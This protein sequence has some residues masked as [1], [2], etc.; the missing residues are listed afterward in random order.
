M[1][2]IEIVF[3]PELPIAVLVAISCLIA[4]MCIWSLLN[5]QP[6]SVLRAVAGTLLCVAI[7]NPSILQEQREPLST[8]IPLVIDQ[9]SSQSQGAR[10]GQTS[11][12]VNEIR[13]QIKRMDG[14]ELREVVVK[15]RISTTS[16]IST[17][18]FAALNNELQDVPRDRIGGYLFVTD[19][20][21][22]D[23]PPIGPRWKD[24]PPLHAFI[25][26]SASERDRKIKFLKAPRFGVVGEI[27]EI[28]FVVE[29]S[30]FG[31]QQPVDVTI[32]MDGEVISVERV[33]PGEEN[34]FE[35]EVPHGGE[36]IVELDV[37]V[38][39]NEIST[40][41]N[42]TFTT[43]NGIRENLRVLLVSGEPYSGERTWRNLLK[44]DTAV[45]LVHFTILRPPEKQDGTLPHELS[46]IPFPTREL[47]LQKI[48]EFDLII[49]DRYA[50]R[51]I[52]PIL[53]FDNIAR[54]VRDGGA[55]LIAA[56]PEYATPRSIDKTP[57][58]SVL[59]AGAN[60]NIHEGGFRPQISVTGEKHP[61]TRDLFGWN[62]GAPN[63]SR[64][65]RTV[66][67]NQTSG[68]AIMEDE[69][70]RPM[71]LLDNNGEGR[72]AL[73]LSDHVWLWSR[74]FEGG[75]PH[76]QLL[77]RLSHWL[78]KEPQLEAER[79]TSKANGD[80]LHITRQTLGDA[81][82][83]VTVTAPD[84]S[85]HVVE[86][87]ADKP[88]LWKGTVDATGLG[89]YRITDGEHTTLAKVG[90]ANPRELASI[91]RTTQ[92]LKPVVEASSGSFHLIGDRSYPRITAISENGTRSGTTW[93]GLIDRNASLLSGVTRIPVFAGLLG[94]ALLVFSI[95]A[96]WFRE[97]R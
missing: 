27:G 66:G 3:S 44:S 59:P 2:N 38:A 19:G 17:A 40:I 16:D 74:N 33:F 4:A 72:V 28:S 6:G 46:L 57:L 7:F 36:N 70:G 18:L 52:L 31:Q 1:E 69:E 34:S 58:V 79:L 25:T 68:E 23:V 5:G 80:Q 26:G 75:G 32:S 15:D 89:L 94:L 64:W 77:R 21:V 42:S 9:T 83:P 85:R 37:E 22:H 93:L 96:M 78:M 45:D 11:E 90:P 12:A 41:N 20:Q 62:D 30:G 88:G 61:V 60:G 95:S 8:I 71:L 48:D 87:Q 49:F 73:F 67:A 82:E 43:L 47:F 14:F 81:P 65:F 97:G 92:L 24:G 86:L 76:A 35:F 54:Y 55:L 56:G 53:Y 63:W 29:E 13:A 51:G 84:G 50:L 39:E 10:A 91:T